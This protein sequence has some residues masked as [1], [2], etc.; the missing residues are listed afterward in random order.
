MAYIVG[1]LVLTQGW[2]G[3]WR[4]ECLTLRAV[5]RRDEGFALMHLLLCTCSY[6]VRLFA[7]YCTV[8]H[9][10]AQCPQGLD[11]SYVSYVS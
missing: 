4:V 1:G 7:Q 8:L 5:L 2:G 6:A 10:I 3:V 9:S 11:I